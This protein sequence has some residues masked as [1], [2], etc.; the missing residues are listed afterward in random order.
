VGK[1]LEIGIA[2]ERSRCSA[3]GESMIRNKFLR[4]I[5]FFAIAAF[6]ISR[7]ATL[8]VDDIVDDSIVTEL[9][10]EGFVAKLYKP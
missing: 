3:Y 4:V 2:G 5:S 9:D 1:I 10:K 8:K 7:S 6:A